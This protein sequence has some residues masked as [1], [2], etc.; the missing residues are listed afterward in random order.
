MSVVNIRSA[1]ASSRPKV[2][3][4]FFE[5]WA[6]CGQNYNEPDRIPEGMLVRPVRPEGIDSPTEPPPDL[7][8]R[9]RGK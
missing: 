8:V 6:E 7:A 1:E 2:D 4:K 9:H 5:D 3:P